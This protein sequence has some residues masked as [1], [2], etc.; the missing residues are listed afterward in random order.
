MTELTFFQSDDGPLAYLDAGEGLP[1]VLVHGGFLDHR[2][3]TAQIPAFAVA[4][5]VIAVDVRGHGASA[6]ATK[7]FRPTDDLAALLQHLGV[8]PAVLVGVS[9]GAGIVVDTALEHPDLVRALVISGAGTSE[10]DFQDPWTLGILAE[11]ARTL[12]VGD[13]EGWVDSF[14]LFAAGP[15]RALA[16]VDQDLVRRQREMALGTISKHTVDE[17]DLLVP[18][19]D[20]WERAK[21]IAVPVLAVHGGIDSDDHIRMAERLVRGV[22]DGRSTTIDGTA[23]YPN[24]ERPELYNEIVGEF[25]R[26]LKDSASGRN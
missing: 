12:P 7:P 18:V 16:D 11:W 2:M 3:W 17:V 20:T 15:H 9:M 4:H 1:L 23:H 26:G 10:P 25:V 6:N 14:L 8:G 13:V 21:S 19:T 24:I 5:R 22:A